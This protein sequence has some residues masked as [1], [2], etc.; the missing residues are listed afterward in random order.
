MCG[1]ETK[2]YYT[3][4]M[5]CQHKE[6]HRMEMERLDKAELLTEYDGWVWSPQILGYQDGYFESIETLVDHMDDEWGSDID[7]TR[8]SRFRVRVQE[9]SA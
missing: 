8:P 4:C 3:R 7:E 6:H 9:E 5:P 1:V 2:T